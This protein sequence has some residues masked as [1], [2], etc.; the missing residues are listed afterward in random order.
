MTKIQVDR[1][2]ECIQILYDLY[3]DAL[4][5]SHHGKTLATATHSQ[6]HTYYLVFKYLKEIIHRQYAKAQQEHNKIKQSSG[7]LHIPP[8]RP[9]SRSRSRSPPSPAYSPTSRRSSSSSSSSDG[10]PSP[11]T[12]LQSSTHI[13]SLQAKDVDDL[14]LQH[15]DIRKILEIYG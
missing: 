12:R 13:A 3:I 4:S 7:P 2:P 5:F 8:P 6:Y 10:I 1:T 15:L 9:Q 14:E 11:P